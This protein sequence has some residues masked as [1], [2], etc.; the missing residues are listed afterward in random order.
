[1]AWAA[2]SVILRLDMASKAEILKELDFVTDKLS[3]QVRTIALGVLVFSWGLIVGE[4]R[5]AENLRQGL[6]W[7]SVGVGAAAIIV[8]LFDFLQYLAGYWNTLFVYQ[9]MKSDRTDK[10]EYDEKSILFRIR[11]FLFYA[12]MTGLTATVI[13][14]ALLLDIG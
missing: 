9:K 6:V 1:M 2:S 3:A 10:G 5:L 12:K 4:S 14:L 13:W 7:H 11:V 8:M